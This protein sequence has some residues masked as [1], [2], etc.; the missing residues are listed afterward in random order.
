MRAKITENMKAFLKE[1]LNEIK[2]EIGDIKKEIQDVSKKT[3]LLE[4]RNEKTEKEVQV[5]KEQNRAMQASITTLECKAL[6]NYLR[7]R[8]VVEE[9]E[10][11]ISEVVS[12]LFAEYLEEQPEEISYNLDMVYRV[13]S[14]YATQNNLPRDVVVQIT[15]KKI[16][17]EI[18]IWAKSFKE[19]LEKEGKTIRILKELPKIVI[20]NRKDFKPLTDKLKKLR[21]RYR[22]EIPFGLSFFFKG[23][24]KLIADKNEMWTI[25]KMFEKEF[26]NI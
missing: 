2:K 7:L 25:M 16:K 18:E 9:K 11:N 26:K 5:L 21:V 19:P 12:A 10:E 13:N 22:W 8:G 14:K 17:E 15:S 20:E 4:M 1:E 3:Q 24:R 6:E 23:K